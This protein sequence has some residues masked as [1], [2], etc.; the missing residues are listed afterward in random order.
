MVL[1]CN[2][3][4]LNGYSSEGREIKPLKCNIKINSIQRTSNDSTK[5]YF[6]LYENPKDTLSTCY[7]KP[8]GLV[9]VTVVRNKLY[10]PIYHSINFDREADSSILKNMNKYDL[11]LWEALK[12]DKEVN[13]WLQ[14]EA[15]NRKYK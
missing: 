10:I 1:L 13:T 6:S 7:L 4:E 11:L 14:A 15:K 3:R 12:N 9:G 8:L 5:F 2:A